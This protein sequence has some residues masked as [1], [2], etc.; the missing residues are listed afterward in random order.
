MKM[1]SKLLRYFGYILFRPIWWL[2]RLVLRNKKVWVFGAWYGQKYSDNSKWLYE[3]VLEH[4]PEIKAVWITK[5]RDVYN[6]LRSQDKP[7]CM[8]ASA[9]GAWWCLRAKYAF[10]SSTQLDVNKFFLNGVKQIWLWH[11]MP[12]KKILKSENNNQ[13][14]KDRLFNMLNPYLRFKPYSTLTASNYFIPFLKEAF[15]LPENRIWKTGLPRCDAFNSKREDS[16]IRT[17]KAKFPNAKIIMYMPTFRKTAGNTGEPF[18]PFVKQ[19]DFD[20][21]QFMNFLVKENVIFLYK[22]HFVDS[23]LIIPVFSDRFIL[24]N[25][26]MFDDLYILLNSVDALL[27]DYSSVYFDFLSAKKN[28]YLLPFDYEMYTKESRSHYFNMFTEMKGCV[29]KSWPS[30]YDVYSTDMMNLEEDNI[31]FNEFNNGNACKLIT[32][33]IITFN[34][35]N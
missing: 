34:K 7:V 3:Y 15:E 25:E 32:D 12:L 27:T 2:E 31:K 18:N 17:L 19:F 16:Y 1:M 9:K 29:C 5:S 21:K 35:G 26:Q 8:S 22:P 30:F 4:N 11:G 13:I 33:R 14:F 10:L 24:L 28:I 6:K 20:D 23:G